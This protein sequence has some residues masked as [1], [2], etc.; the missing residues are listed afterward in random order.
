[1][2]IKLYDTNPYDR[3]FNAVVQT[4]GKAGLSGAGD[5]APV[6]FAVTLDQTLFFPEEGG[7]S[8][9]T[10]VL[11][12]RLSNANKPSVSV[13]DVQIEGEEIIHYCDRPIEPGS[14]ITG[15]I[16]WDHR[17]DKMQQHTGEHIVSG[18]VNKYYGY[19][20][21]GFHLSNDTVTMD[22]DREL[23]AEQISRLELLANQAI[24]ENLP[25]TAWYPPAE[26]L[27]TLR[28]RSKIDLAE[29]VRLVKIDG[30]DLCACCAPHVSSTAQVGLLKIVDYR[31]YKGGMRLWIKC[32]GRALEDYGMLHDQ[33]AAISAELS[34]PRDALLEPVVRAGREIEALKTELAA[35]NAALLQSKI[36]SIPSDQQD[37][38]LFEPGM[39][40]V[41]ILRDA[42]NELAAARSGYCCVFF[43][44]SISESEVQTER[45]AA[46]RSAAPVWRYICASTGSDCRAWNEDLKK[47]FTVRGGGKESMVQGSVTASQEDLSAWLSSR[48]KE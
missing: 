19:S 2:T 1:M 3:S 44:C 32:G 37:V 5:D 27:K 38:T 34:A 31:R 16:D 26:E 10:G 24:W 17:F 14:E 43:D 13:L 6:L 42:L 41:K 7:Q 12:P 25:V 48:D 36:L 15:R 9:D 45:A 39:N 40:D 47:A 18:L 33:T 46:D 11:T 35:A 4:C 23:T 30:V 21:V 28:Y 29:G 20:N 8:P 22:Y